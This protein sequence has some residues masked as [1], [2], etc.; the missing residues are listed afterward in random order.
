MVDRLRLDKG[1]KQEKKREKREDAAAWHGGS[2]GDC[3]LYAPIQRE[4]RTLP[5]SISE[6]KSLLETAS[7]GIH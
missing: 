7:K 5:Q 6:G 4:E 3:I 1:K 2:M